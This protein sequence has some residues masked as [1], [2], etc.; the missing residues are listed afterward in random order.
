M[1][2]TG[3]LLFFLLMNYIIPSAQT[4]EKKY[5]NQIISESIT[6]TVVR[7]PNFNSKFVDSRNV[8]IWLPEGYDSALTEKYPVLYMHDGQNVFDAK[9]SFIGVDWGVDE[10]MTKLIS[11]SKIKK[12]IIV[13]VWNNG[14]KR[15]TEYMPNKAYSKLKNQ[16]IL[17]MI[18]S[19]FTSDPLS[20]QYLSFLVSELKPFIDSTYRTLTT[21]DNTFIGGSSMGGLISAYAVCE[22]PE[23]FGGAACLST[24]WTTGEGIMIDYLSEKLPDPATHKFY[25]DYGTL[26]LDAQ[27]E[28]YQKKMDEI[29]KTKGWTEN[30]NW[31]TRKYEGEEHSE[32]AWK[33]RIDIPLVFLL[34]K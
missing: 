14:D 25:F 5:N 30:V 20:D 26:T 18:K 7:Y 13:A 8:D 32:R 34:G 24:H 12:A 11:D 29:M 23:I 33:K 2:M 19:R 4:I 15:F 6:G 16:N 28:P 27:Y 3:S 1:K 22:Y 21:R 9:T 10:T 17:S 31:I